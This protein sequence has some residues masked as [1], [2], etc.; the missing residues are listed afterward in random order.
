MT[1]LSLEVRS[2]IELNNCSV[3]GQLGWMRFTL[4]VVGLPQLTCLCNVAWR[5]GGGLDYIAPIHYQC[6]QEFVQSVCMFFVDLENLFDC[7]SQ[8]I[9]CEVFREYG[10]S[11]QLLLAI[12]SLYNCSMSLV[13]IEY[14][15]LDSFPV[16]VGFCQGCPLSQIHSFYEQ[17]IQTQPDGGVSNLV[18]FVEKHLCFL[19][20]MCFCCLHQ[21]VTSRLLWD[22]Y[23]TFVTCCNVDFIPGFRGQEN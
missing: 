19:Q 13:C 11:G 4:D 1:R 15:N 7:I 2:L 17:N 3:V 23:R 18:G 10:M 22:S 20:I 16:C 9:L 8:D 5:S 14:S 21:L 6:A 12:R